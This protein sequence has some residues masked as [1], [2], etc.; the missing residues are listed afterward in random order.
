MMY[1]SGEMITPLP[2]PCW[3]CGCCGDHL[4]AAAELALEELLHVVG[5]TFGHVLLHHRAF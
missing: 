4:A 5:Q 3:N 1:P 2:M